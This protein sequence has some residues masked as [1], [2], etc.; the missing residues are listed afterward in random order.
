MISYPGTSISPFPARGGATNIS[1]RGAR[2]RVREHGL[3]LEILAWR[4]SNNDV[5]W[6]AHLIV[7]D[8]DANERVVQR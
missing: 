8:G 4:I 2:L 7:D 6:F 3:A 5:A 1:T